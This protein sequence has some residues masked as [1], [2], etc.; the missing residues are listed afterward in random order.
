VR[1]QS[2]LDSARYYAERVIANSGKRL[3]STYGE[4]FRWNYDNKPESLFE[5]QWVFLSG[6]PGYGV[7]NS[8]PSYLNYSSEMS[9]EGWGGD[10]G[11]TYWMLGNYEGFEPSG[12]TM[13]VGRT[14][15]QRLRETFMLPG[16]QYPEITQTVNGVN[17]KLLFPYQNQD[18]NF[19]SVKKYVVGKSADL[20]IL[21][22]AQR[23][24][25]NTYMLRLAE[26]YLI[27]AE[28]I[29]GN[30]ASTIDAAALAAYNKV[31]MRAGLPERVDPITMNVLPLTMDVIIKER[32]L[33]FAMESSAWYDLVSLHY[34]NPQKAY[35]ILNS[36]DRG[37]FK[38]I[39]DVMPNP[40]QWQ[41]K[42]TPWANT[43]RKIN[44][45]SGNFLLP[46]PAKEKTQAP[47]LADAAVE[48]P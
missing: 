6:G 4:L 24:P 5:L 23:Y 33:E 22:E 44:A 47:Y 9:V 34:W 1:N 14:L 38:V 15:D 2:F 30:S 10:K 40:T 13:L 39:P 42:K 36:Q 12:D 32:F 16:T 26:M 28:A 21:V 37:Y 7:G 8:A 19:A 46:I 11:A 43:D 17:Q 31:R 41:I 25:N 48:Y 18:V 35:D 3:L 27:V 45:S 20:G 29:L